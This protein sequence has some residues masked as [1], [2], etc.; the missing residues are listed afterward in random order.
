[1]DKRPITVA[2]PF[3]P[4]F[5][6]DMSI[7][8][9]KGV[10]GGSYTHSMWDGSVWQEI[11]FS[12]GAAIHNGSP[13]VIELLIPRTLL[14]NP[15]FLNIG[16]VSTDRARIH[17]ASDILGSDVSPSDW[18]EPVILDTFARFEIK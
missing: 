11:T 18:E 6:L 2:D 15:A 5:R 10:V 4:E 8:D 16:V 13:S 12:G 14:G 1:V 17:T 7:A 3:T 9:Q